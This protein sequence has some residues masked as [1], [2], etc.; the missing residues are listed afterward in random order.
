M[1]FLFAEF[2]FEMYLKL[3][4][5]PTLQVNPTKNIISSMAYKNRLLVLYICIYIYGPFSASIILF[6]SIVIYINLMSKKYSVLIGVRIECFNIYTYDPRSA[7]P[8]M[9]MTGIQL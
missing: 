9:I 4:F 5:N 1:S 3:L 7:Q 8:T 6:E 2:V